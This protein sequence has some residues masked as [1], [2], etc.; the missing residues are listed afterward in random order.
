[1]SRDAFNEAAEAKEQLE[2]D[3]LDHM[4]AY[5]FEKATGLKGIAGNYKYP[6]GLNAV[7][8]DDAWTWT[9]RQY[10]GGIEALPK[11]LVA[12]NVPMP[13]F[14]LHE[15]IGAYLNR[16]P[17][18]LQDA[19]RNVWDETVA[20]NPSLKAVRLDKNDIGKVYDAINGAASGFNANDINYYFEADSSDDARRTYFE[21]PRRLR[22]EDETGARPCWIASPE[23]LDAI[24]L[25]LDERQARAAAIRRTGPD[26]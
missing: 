24:C 21:D 17:K 11:A 2:R 3:M 14:G 23:T 25:K 16:A 10:G 13:E 22:I 19:L 12:K 18:E 9:F 1:M 20:L 7:E 8:F 5:R 4:P 6:G 26:L 15:E